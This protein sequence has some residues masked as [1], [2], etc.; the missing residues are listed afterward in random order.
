MSAL[1]AGG[2]PRVSV[3]I[4][5]FNMASTVGRAIESVLGQTLADLELI[6][7][8]NVSTD[9]TEEVCR[10]YAAADAR[11]RYSRRRSPIPACDNFRHVLGTACA[12]YFMW[13]SADDCA[14]PALLERAVAVLDAHPEVVCAAPRVDFRR[15]D[16]THQPA[17]GTFALLGGVAD[18]LRRFLYDPMDNCRF[19]GVFRRDVLTRA[20]PV[21][22]DYHAWDWAVSAATLRWGTHWEL[23]DTL[24]VRAANE[25]D[26]YT[27]SIDRAFASAP[28]RLLPLL[29]FT[30][31]LLLDARVPPAPRLLYQL[32]RLNLV[33]H[34][35]YAR[36]R[37][38]RYGRVAYRVSAGI[39]RAAGAAWRALW[40]AR[41]PTA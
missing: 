35:T 8:D 1:P 28:A 10:Q 41:R 13:L 6:V 33:Y 15:A 25:P 37:Y 19:Y 3:G 11:V 20:M 17:G 21:V 40:R 26:K 36:Y 16:G 32:A 39:E 23:S 5:V 22:R 4:P 30:R 7:S 24:L 12:P 18:N 29:P 34:V 9:A 2:A 27:R 38:P 31:A 14:R